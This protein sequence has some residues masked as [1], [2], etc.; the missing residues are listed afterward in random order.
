GR[1]TDLAI[2]GDGFFIVDGAE[3]LYTRDGSFS[4]DAENR[5]V[6]ADGLFVQGYG[7]DEEGEIVDGVLA[8]VE[9][10]L[11]GM[12]MAKQTETAA[13]S[14][15]LNA[16]G[17]LATSAGIIESGIEIFSGGGPVTGAT[18][19]TA[20]EDATAT[21]LFTVG[22]VVS[23]EGTRGSRLQDR[24]E[25][26]VE[27]TTTVAD[28]QSFFE[29]GLGILPGVAQPA[30]S[31]SGASL[32]AGPTTGTTLV[33]TSNT[34]TAN[35]V[36]I[37]GSAL[38]LNGS[39]LMTF[40]TGSDGL[41]N[42]HN[43]VGESIHTQMVAYDSLGV[44]MTIDVTMTLESTDTTGTTWR[45]IA[46]S[47]DD[48]RYAGGAN[49]V[50]GASGQILGT[51]TVSFDTDG[52]KID[53]GTSEIVTVD[54]TDTGAEP[55]VDIELDFDQVTSLASPEST[56]FTQQDGVPIGTLV[57][58]GIAGNGI[59]TG[60]FDNGLS[61]TLGQIGMATFENNL[62]LL[63]QGGGFYTI[64]ANSGEPR[65][66]RPLEASAGSV[67]AG[68]LELSNVDL[69]QEFVNLIIASTGFSAA[70]RVI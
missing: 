56:M 23:L 28:L 20:V 66:G 42:L 6:T 62:G 7:V 15:N 37:E 54:R 57:G 14:G 59:I 46:A 60:S 18:L 55:L 36:A 48:V 12:T 26:N 8:N 27:A 13:L 65:I 70:S 19:L 30:G 22:D 68:A 11:G 67:R 43:P 44:P 50:A 35:N 51:G 31:T 2:D 45:Y 39:T 21:P 9:I 34:G 4:I 25:L 49:F 69:S 10:P 63:D 17:D 24:I 38:Q 64:G 53:D 47:P 41:G 33:L 16:D 58:F 3:Q 61:T 52:R 40:Q 32:K 29:Q 5:L 1:L